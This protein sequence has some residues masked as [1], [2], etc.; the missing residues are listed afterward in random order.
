MKKQI[1]KELLNYY[2]K[3]NKL[4]DSNIEKDK[5]KLSIIKMMIKRIKLILKLSK[6]V[7]IEKIIKYEKILLDKNYNKNLG[8]MDGLYVLKWLEYSK[9]LDRVSNKKLNNYC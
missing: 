5:V 6:Y 9:F 3:K 7:E 4:E 8:S 1:E 2:I